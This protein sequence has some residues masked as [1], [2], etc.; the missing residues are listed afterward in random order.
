MFF[1]QISTRHFFQCSKS[2]YEQEGAVYFIQFS[3]LRKFSI[4][5]VY[6]TSSYVKS[7]K[8]PIGYTETVFQ[9]NYEYTKCHRRL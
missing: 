1:K 8:N 3:L 9:C 6:N 7:T 4:L 2:K 5:S